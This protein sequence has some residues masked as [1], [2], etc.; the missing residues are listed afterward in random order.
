MR[1]KYLTLVFCLIAGFSAKAQLTDTV[2]A[3][4]LQ[5]AI[6]YAQTHQSSILNA[7]IDEEIARNTVKKTTGIGLPQVNANINFQDFIKVPT[8]LLPGEFFDKPGE[9]IPV[10]FGVKYQSSA[11]VELSQLL[12]DGTYLVGLQ[13]S[14][15]YKELS[16][17][18]LQ[19]S[20]IETA[21]AVTKAYYS[22][23]VSNEQLNL[24]D[25][26]IE[27]LK[28]SLKDTEALFKNGFVEKIDLDRLTVLN[29]N[30]ETERGNVIRLLDLNLHLLKF[31]MG[32]NI[33]STLTLKDSISNLNVE[34][35]VALNDTAAY[36]S[37]IE[38]SLLETQKKLNELDLKRY[39]SQYLPSI[40]AFGS[41]TRSL[42]SNT[43]NELFDRSFPMTVIGFR[44]SVP[45]I[46]G[47]IRNYQ[48]RNAKLEIQKTE[49][50]LVNLRNG[51]NLEVEQ[52]KTVYRNGFKSLEN[53]KRNMTL[54]QE[55]LRVTKVKYE[56]GVGSSIEVTTAE[57]S[58]KESQNNYINALYELL[59]NKVN[60]DKAL[61]K[62][63]Y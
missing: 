34:E 9:M 40:G 23:L 35:S 37:R 21:V 46:S 38:Y 25:A 4:T 36:K 61:G 22:V 45:I 52:A 20:R 33:N 1:Y 57:T 10:R 27:R 28:K 17:K 26:N 39:K 24:L 62:I 11:G 49:N 30:L 2:A 5:E 32:M 42:Q 6:D 55:V 44:V 18:S 48:V 63:I 12:F 8:N 14:K 59:I 41:T 43:F 58:L 47:G 54:A 15:T 60:L 3:F 50:N 19:R 53:Q 51:I 29:N 56:Q 7:K 31:Q 13:A 16:T